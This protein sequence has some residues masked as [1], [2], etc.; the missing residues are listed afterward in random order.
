[1]LVDGIQ[2]MYDGGWNPS[3]ESDNSKSEQ[4]RGSQSKPEQARAS[5]H[6]VGLEHHCTLYYYTGCD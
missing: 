3:A 2:R 1:V 5:H 6:C 4:V